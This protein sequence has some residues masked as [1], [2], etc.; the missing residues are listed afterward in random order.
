MYSMDIDSI[1][2]FNTGMEQKINIIEANNTYDK[3][4]KFIL[5]N[6]IFVIYTIIF[7]LLFTII[8][9][10]GKN[11]GLNSII[12]LSIVMLIILIVFYIFNIY[13]LFA[14]IVLKY[15]YLIKYIWLFMCLLCIGLTVLSFFTFYLSTSV[16]LI[17]MSSIYG[18]LF[19]FN[20]Y[21]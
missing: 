7:T 5:M 12:S 8:N 14:N 2:I 19:V 10:I 6:L 15:M 11:N 9:S 4:N 17:I 3:K 20:L 13:E 16:L 18:I 21:Y 1:N